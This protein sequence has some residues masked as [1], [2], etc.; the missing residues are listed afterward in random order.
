MF[1][2]VHLAVTVSTRLAK[3]SL[4]WQDGMRFSEREE[5][6]AVKEWAQGIGIK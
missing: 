2:F 5:E 6:S 3:I 1:C 4:R